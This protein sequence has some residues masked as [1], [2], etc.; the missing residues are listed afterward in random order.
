MWTHSTAIAAGLCDPGAHPEHMNH[1]VP[2]SPRV[3]LRHGRTPRIALH[4]RLA[5]AVVTC[6]LVLC[7]L[8][9]TPASTA[10]AADRD[11]VFPVESDHVLR[12]FD[13]SHGKYGAG[14]R[15]VDL[16]AGLGDPLV[17]PVDGVVRFVGFVVDR[18]VITV[19]SDSGELLSFEPVA[20]LVVVGERVT[21]GQHLAT[22]VSGHLPCGSCLHFGVRLNDEYV[23]PLQY[24]S[25]EQAVLLPLEP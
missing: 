7:A 6:V 20:P 18:T 2:P 24:F 4:Q 5:G 15:G 9:S 16:D 10:F 8:G 14:H 17:S 23:N 19:E 12:A 1:T 13:L 25:M 11:W 3:S 21:A 22:V